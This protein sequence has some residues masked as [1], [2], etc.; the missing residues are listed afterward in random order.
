VSEAPGAEV[1]RL[2][3]ILVELELSSAV[4]RRD[5]TGSTWLPAEAR[6]LVQAHPACRRALDEFVACELGLWRV[7]QDDPLALPPVDPFFTARVVGALP[8]PQAGTRLSPQRRALVL[9]LFHV[10]AGLLTYAVVTMVPESTARWAEQAHT[11]LSWGSE[12][13]SVGLGA[14]AVA[15]A[16]FLALAVGRTHSPTA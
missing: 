1:E 15:G 16:V 4:L 13:G 12:L 3:S 9:G 14:A 5:P 10:I 2:E 7:S 6:A 11:M 8:D